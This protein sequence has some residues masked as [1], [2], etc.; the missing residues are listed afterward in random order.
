MC[1]RKPIQFIRFFLTRANKYRIIMIC[2]CVPHWPCMAIF[3][4]TKYPRDDHLHVGTCLFFIVFFMYF[5][6]IRRVHRDDSMNKYLIIINWSTT[7]N[8]IIIIKLAAGRSRNPSLWNTQSFRVF[9]GKK[10]SEESTGDRRRRHHECFGQNP[11]ATGKKFS[12][13]SDR[14]CYL[15]FIQFCFF[16]FCFIHVGTSSP[17]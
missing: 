4:G 14:Y 10:T 9:S 2:G 1:I 6:R 15:L 5:R 17:E 16:V 11:V 13:F 7:F 3:P 8:N 12:R